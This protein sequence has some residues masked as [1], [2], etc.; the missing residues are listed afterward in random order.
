MI[1][2][3]MYGLGDNFYQRAIIRELGPVSLYTPWP[4]IYADLPVRC[5]KPQ[6][7]LR[8]QKKHIEK[9]NF[10]NFRPSGIKKR[11]F[12]DQRGTIIEALE[13]SIGV[14]NANLSIKMPRLGLKKKKTIIVR[15]C[16][17]RAEWPASARNC[18]PKYLCQAVEALKDEFHIVSIADLEDGKEWIDGDAPF[19]H[20]KYHA[21]ELSLTDIMTLLESSAGSIGSVGWLL[22]ASM[23]YNLPMLCI[24]GGWGSSNC[25]E[26]LFDS[27][28]DDNMIV[29][30]IPDNFCMCSR[31]DH[32]CDKQITN[33]EKYID[34]FRSIARN[35]HKA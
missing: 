28:I 31:H 22:P 10:D 17:V 25:P 26:R 6:T 2:Q 35:G 4:E 15:P 12:Y 32:K 9:S 13:R 8:T 11:L 16:T 19:A 27:R 23:A 3:G 14:K 24:F 18:D 30:A 21:G 20:E 5:L 29:K 7:T 33:F 1:I 34:E